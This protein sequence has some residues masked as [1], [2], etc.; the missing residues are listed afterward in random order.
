MVFGWRI[1]VFEGRI[2]I[3][4]AQK[5]YPFAED[6]MEPQN[7]CTEERGRKELL[8]WNFFKMGGNPQDFKGNPPPRPK[9]NKE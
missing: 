8:N 5:L 4:L 6:L 3:D 9:F 7:E 2:K 1:Q